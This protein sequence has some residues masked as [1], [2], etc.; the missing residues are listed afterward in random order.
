MALLCYV[1]QS[2]Y[3]QAGEFSG[4]VPENE[5]DNASC[6]VRQNGV[7]ILSLPILSSVDGLE[8]TLV[9]RESAGYCP[10]PLD[11]NVKW[12]YGTGV[13]NSL[14][15]EGGAL[16]LAGQRQGEEV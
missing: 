5:C 2:H 15:G 16:A 7:P 6:S 8:K 13:G 4:A 1:R 3:N 9:A 12:H 10:S 14:S 11:A